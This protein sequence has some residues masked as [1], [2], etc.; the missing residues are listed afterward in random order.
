[1]VQDVNHSDTN[2]NL[3]KS[4]ESNSVILDSHGWSSPSFQSPQISP[5]ER[6]NMQ[7]SMPDV[8]RA[9]LMVEGATKCLSE[10]KK[11][12]LNHPMGWLGNES[13]LVQISYWKLFNV[14]LMTAIYKNY[15]RVRGM[16]LCTRYFSRLLN[17]WNGCWWGAV[18]NQRHVSR[19][20]V[21]LIVVCIWPS[22]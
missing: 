10:C 3:N 8:N 6:S 4:L 13:S 15:V 9:L 21:L 14:A 17:I 11:F 22:I 2:I 1:M 12:H 5:R 16:M 19:N 7:F 20:T 18:K